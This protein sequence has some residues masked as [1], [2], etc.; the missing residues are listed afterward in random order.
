L[1]VC[2]LLQDL[3]GG[4]A[5]RVML[6]LASEL[7]RA[8]RRVELLLIRATGPYLAEVP[9][10]LGPVLLGP[11][12]T[13]DTLPA[14]VR[15]LQRRRPAWLVS[16]LSHVN[17]LAIAARRVARSETR[18]LVTEHNRVRGNPHLAGGQAARWLMP[19]VY[20]FADRIVAVSEGVADDLACAARLRRRRIEV[21]YN[22]IVGPRIAALGAES[23]P[24]PWLDDRGAPVIIG[25][26]RLERQ[27]DFATLLHAFALVRAELPARLVILGEGQERHALMQKARELGIDSDCTLP[28]FVT[29]PYCWLARA[30]LFVLSSTWEGL[31]TALVEA[32]ACGVPVVA[33]DC[34]HGPREILKNGEFGPLVPP[35][36]PLALA[37]AMRT[38]LRTPLAGRILVERAAEFS[39][40]RAVDRYGS[41][42]CGT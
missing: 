13:R 17:L 21:V 22:P 32:L 23:S 31:P 20:R 37:E 18:V 19:C 16:S 3:A 27:K 1:P 33:T 5:E 40:A 26:G 9:A 36:N 8:G 42:L 34:P 35:G 25:I 15:Y 7:A 12:R 24:H 39:I 41:L 6:V 11:R 2:F 28:G 38:A 10:A 30:S 4:G 29:N 14:L